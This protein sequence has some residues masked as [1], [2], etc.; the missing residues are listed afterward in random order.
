MSVQRKELRNINKAES[1]TNQLLTLKLEQDQK[2]IVAT[3]C[4]AI[5]VDYI[6]GMEGTKKDPKQA[7]E[8]M[9]RAT[10]LDLKEAYYNLSDMYFYGYGTE[11]NFKKS[12][13]MIKRGDQLKETPYNYNHQK[14]IFSLP[15]RFFIYLIQPRFLG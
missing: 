8:W 10:D 11:V 7:F 13:A 5:S 6:F 4:M 1:L 14:H 2:N 15:E 9:K 3:Y 12:I